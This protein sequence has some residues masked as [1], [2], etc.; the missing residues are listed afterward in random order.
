MVRKEDIV[1]S[2][3]NVGLSKGDDVIFHSSLKSF[4]YVEG[5]PETVISAF[6]DVVTE[7][8]TVMVPTLCQK[9]FQNSYKTW[10]INKP[11]DTGLI[12]EV[13]RLMP[14][15]LRSNQGTHSIAAIGKRAEYYTKDH[16]K[17]G[18]RLGRYGYTPFSGDSPW[19]K[20]YDNNAVIILLGVDFKS[21]TLKHLIEYLLVEHKLK[22][23]REKGEYDKYASMILRFD[24][25]IDAREGYIWPYIAPQKLDDFVKE[26]NLYKE[27]MCK[28][29]KI[30][31][32][33]AKDMGELLYND[34]LKRPE[35][36]YEEHD[37]RVLKWMLMNI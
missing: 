16:G 34:L 2:L 26:N 14:E 5:G 17:D 1:A 12:T 28:E 13:F 21:Y 22:E 19:Q 33:R 10:N 6:L 11:S 20:I 15:A 23:A 4:G 32:V 31:F 24:V 3:K 18:L 36:W 25:P 8:G 9:D 27:T 35:Y 29:C 30:I 37:E 7:N